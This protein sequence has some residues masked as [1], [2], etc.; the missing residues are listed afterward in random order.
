MYQEDAS[1]KKSMLGGNSP[2]YQALCLAVRYSAYMG[3]ELLTSLEQKERPSSA[4]ATAVAAEEETRGGE[5]VMRVV[6]EPTCAALGL[7][8]GAMSP[9][10]RMFVTHYRCTFC[11]MLPLYM[12]DLSHY[13]RA[14]CG[15]CGQLVSFS[16]TGKYGRARKQ[17]A[18][19]I[20]KRRMEKA[21]GG[22]GGGGGLDGL[23]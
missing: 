9:I 20:W 10:Q 14:R 12:L 11:K 7:N 8:Y 15:K 6:V 16:T 22:G 19:A 13:S 2:F 23:P 5:L 17:V 3:K 18:I 4:A 1:D 21:G